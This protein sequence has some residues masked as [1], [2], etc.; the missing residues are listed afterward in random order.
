MLYV[1]EIDLGR[2]KL[3]QKVEVKIDSYPDKIFDGKVTYISSSAEF[4]PKNIQ[5]KE[6]RSKLVFGVKAEI[7]NA[8]KILKPGMPADASIITSN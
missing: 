8:E 3:G 6:D 1:N 2:V 4:T 5:S 7:N